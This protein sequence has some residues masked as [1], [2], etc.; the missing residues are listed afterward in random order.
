MIRMYGDR[1]AALGLS[2]EDILGVQSKK[3][4]KAAPGSDM[5]GKEIGGGDS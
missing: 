1:W 3:K 4:G 5:K 2:L